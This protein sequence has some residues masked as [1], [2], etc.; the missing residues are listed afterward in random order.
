[1]NITKYKFKCLPFDD[2]ME[3]IISGGIQCDIAVG[4]ITLTS[5]RIEQGVQFTFPTY[6]ATLGALVAGSVKKG[7]TWSFLAPMHWTVWV[8]FGVTTLLV[9]VV[10]FIIESYSVHG[11]IDGNDVSSGIMQAMYDGVV[12]VL[13]FGS[14]GVHSIEGRLVAIGYGFLVLI[15]VNT[16]VANLTAFLTLTSINSPIRMM[17]DLPGKDIAAGGVYKRQLALAK[18]DIDDYFTSSA[19]D[20]MIKELT[21]G[22]HEVLL[23]DD[24]WIRYQAGKSC[25]LFSFVG[26]LVPFEYAF[27][28]PKRLRHMVSDFSRTLVHLQEIGL[29]LDLRAELVSYSTNAECPGQDPV[30]SDTESVNFSNMIGLW[31]ILF[32]CV[33]TSFALTAV[34]WLIA[35]WKLTRTDS[36]S[37]ENIGKSVRMSMVLS[38]EYHPNAALKRTK[39]IALARANSQKVVTM[40]EHITGKRLSPQGSF[41]ESCR[42]FQEEVE[43]EIENMQSLMH[44]IMCKYHEPEA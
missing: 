22:K 44:S 28:L 37:L 3:D 21:E 13:N 33:G 5:K 12:M 15:F 43:Q 18:L 26:H 25:E 32:V 27:A 17:D 9:P 11:F 20:D 34:K 23:Y 36:F 24:P 2:M 6:H 14:F 35:A 4:G 19:K 42:S 10:V 16:Y 30:S 8:A 7:G 41:Q 31:I 1:M 39:S 29:M 38:S 40:S